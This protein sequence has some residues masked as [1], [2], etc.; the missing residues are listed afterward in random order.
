M[1]P[2]RQAEGE[3]EVRAAEPDDAEALVQLTAAGWRAAY[4]GMVPRRMIER[5]PIAAWRHDIGT[6]LRAPVADAF[7]YVAELNGALAGYCYVAAPGRE[8][9]EGSRVAELVA[10]YVEPERWRLGVGRALAES[11]AGEA[12]RL[13]YEQIKLWTF[14]SNARARAFYLA[15]GWRLDGERQPHPASGTPLVGMRRT[16]GASQ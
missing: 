3:V 15:L 16:L 2:N 1:P 12:A 11:A 14:E 6:G 5:L 7:T 10:I 9:P 4:Q 8:E 13:G